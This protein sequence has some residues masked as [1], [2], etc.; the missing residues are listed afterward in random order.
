MA[1]IEF[2]DVSKIYTMGQT[3]IRALDHI[4]F[5]VEKGEIVCHRRARAGA[6]KTTLLEHIGR[7]GH[8]SPR[9]RCCSTG[10]T[11]AGLIIAVSSPPIAADDV[12]FVFQFYNPDPE[13]H[14]AGKRRARRRSSAGTAARSRSEALRGRRAA[15]AACSNFPAQLSGGEQQRVRHRAGAGEEPQAAPLRRADR[16]ARL[17]HRQGRPQAAAGHLPPQRGKTVAHHYAQRRP[18]RRSPST[19]RSASRTAPWST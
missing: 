14:R 5:A 12:G 13:P 18:D 16:R 19:S 9:A 4:S 3:Q 8:G 1:Y 15:G 2:K 11:S 10:A 7:H 6:G 17:R